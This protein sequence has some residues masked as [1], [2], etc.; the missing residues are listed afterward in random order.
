MMFIW[1]RLDLKDMGIPSAVDHKD[2]QNFI[3]NTEWMVYINP[4]LVVDDSTIIRLLRS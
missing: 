4:L 3:Y 2:P 1:L